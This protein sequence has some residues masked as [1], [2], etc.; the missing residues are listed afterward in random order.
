MCSFGFASEM[1][2]Q[3]LYQQIHEFQQQMGQI[4]GPSLAFL[5]A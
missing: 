4:Q 1:F 2:E 5:F 3:A